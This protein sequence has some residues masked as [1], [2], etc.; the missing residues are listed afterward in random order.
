MN[1][2]KRIRAE[3]ISLISMIVGIAAALS[4][5]PLLWFAS[6]LA[7]D[8]VQ[9][10]FVYGYPV[11]SIAGLTLGIIGLIKSARLNPRSTKGVVFAVIGIVLCLLALAASGWLL[12]MFLFVH[13]VEIAL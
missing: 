1:D 12:L 4:W 9:A 8:F 11:L 2:L 5:I 6:D 13:P 7:S 3:R 10:I